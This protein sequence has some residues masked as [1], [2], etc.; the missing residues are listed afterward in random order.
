MAPVRSAFQVG[1]GLRGRRLQLY[2]QALSAAAL[3]EPG[4]AGAMQS[5]P[6]LANDKRGAPVY[7]MGLTCSQRADGVWLV[8]CKA[9]SSL[10]ASTT[11]LAIVRGCSFPLAIVC[12]LAAFALQALP[13]LNGVEMT[14]AVLGV[15]LVWAVPLLWAVVP[16]TCSCFGASRCVPSC[17]PK[18]GSKL[19]A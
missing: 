14:S 13:R 15:L 4:C 6:R 17:P 18:G 7:E 9:P 1:D 10:L 3:S 11:G 2:N 12:Y 5:V 19:D 8:S 16:T